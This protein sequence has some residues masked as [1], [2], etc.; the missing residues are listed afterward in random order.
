MEREIVKYKDLFLMTT[1]LAFVSLA[2]ALPIY[3][4]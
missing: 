3:S 2:I 1:I 4:T